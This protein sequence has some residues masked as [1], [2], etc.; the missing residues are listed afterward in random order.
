VYVVG[1]FETFEPAQPNRKK[2]IA[3]IS[4]LFMF[5]LRCVWG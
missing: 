3:A 4:N 5:Y 2:D 1:M